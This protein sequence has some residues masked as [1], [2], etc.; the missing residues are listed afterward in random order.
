MSSSTGMAL[1]DGRDDGA[2]QA[3]EPDRCP[4]RTLATGRL[5]A[6]SADNPSVE[7]KAPVLMASWLPR[8][9]SSLETYDHEFER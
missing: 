7:T 2:E 8:R 9:R 6:R 1:A 4:T 3:A 5:A